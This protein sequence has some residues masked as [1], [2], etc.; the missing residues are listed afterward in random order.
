[1]KTELPEYTN[2]E[3]EALIAERVHSERDRAI[4][5][6]RLIDGICYEP[7]AEEFGVSVSQ[8]KRIIYNGQ[9]KIFR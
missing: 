2:S 1:M 8:I 4:L 6:R 5:R 9:D 7:L 3:V